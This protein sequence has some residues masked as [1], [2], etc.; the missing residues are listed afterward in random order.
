MAG[1][2]EATHRSFTLTRRLMGVLS[3]VVEAFVLAMLHAGHDLLVRCLVAAQLVGDQHA[4]H[5]LTAFEQLAEE[6]LGGRLVAPALDQDIQH[7]AVL[8]DGAP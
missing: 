6:L 8:I 4:R 2:L 1:R 3:A 5:I 7:V